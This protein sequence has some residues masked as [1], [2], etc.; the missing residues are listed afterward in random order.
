MFDAN[1]F[2]KEVERGIER[3][4]NM[5]DEGNRVVGFAGGVLPVAECD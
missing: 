1:I 3:E 5:I 2:V 4:E